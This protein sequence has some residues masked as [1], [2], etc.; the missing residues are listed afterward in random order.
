[1]WAAIVTLFRNIVAF[2]SGDSVPRRIVVH[3]LIVAG[4]LVP[5]KIAA[6]SS[7]MPQ[8]RSPRIGAAD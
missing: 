6:E 3:T 4:F 7:K 1:M 8:E 2:F 5:I